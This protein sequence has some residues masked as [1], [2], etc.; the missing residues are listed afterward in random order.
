MGLGKFPQSLGHASGQALSWAHLLRPRAALWRAVSWSPTLGAP[1]REVLAGPGLLTRC[2]PHVC[3][4]TVSLSGSQP[5]LCSLGTEWPLD[6]AGEGDEA[7]SSHGL[8]FCALWPDHRAQQ[9]A[10][11][12]TPTRGSWAPGGPPERGPKTRGPSGLCDGSRFPPR[13]QPRLRG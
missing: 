9:D 12:R 4:N 5:G 2:L 3:V 13:P 1:H 11:R 10:A 6:L 7:G 8:L